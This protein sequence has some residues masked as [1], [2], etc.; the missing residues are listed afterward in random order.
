MHAS[1]L[2]QSHHAQ[3]TEKSFKTKSHSTTGALIQVHNISVPIIKKDNLTVNGTNS[4][5]AMI[6]SKAK[7]D[8]GHFTR[9]KGK[10][11]NSGIKVWISLNEATTARKLENHLLQL[12]MKCLFP[13]INFTEIQI[14]FWKD[15]NYSLAK[16]FLRANKGIWTPSRMLYR[17]TSWHLSYIHFS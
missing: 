17:E 11:P 8:R 2:A 10:Q 6:A 9:L 5:T 7:L 3:D 16:L 4:W 14:V 13:S 1:F 15:R 12:A